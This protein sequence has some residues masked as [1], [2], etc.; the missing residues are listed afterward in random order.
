LPYI[1]EIFDFILHINDHLN[2]IIQNFGIWAYLIL[3]LIIFA[4]TGLVV[5]PFLPGDSLLFVIGTFCALDSLNIFSTFIILC[6]AA[7]VGDSVN[8]SVGRF[9]GPKVFKYDDGFFFK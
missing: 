6:L 5:T 8:Y 9:I 3:F 2:L 1:K 7:I 4:E